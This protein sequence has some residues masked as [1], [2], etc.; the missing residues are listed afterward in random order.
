MTQTEAHPQQVLL[1]G[2]EFAKFH[3]TNKLNSLLF[4]EGCQTCC[5]NKRWVKH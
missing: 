1:A 5:T 4:G 2:R 3:N